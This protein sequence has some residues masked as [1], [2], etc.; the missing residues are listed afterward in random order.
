MNEND[1]ADFSD[2][3]TPC[4]SR[5]LTE[6]MPVSNTVANVEQTENDTGDVNTLIA[7]MRSACGNAESFRKFAGLSPRNL[8]DENA[9]IM[10]TIEEEE[11]RTD[12]AMSEIELEV[13]QLLLHSENEVRSFRFNGTCFF[14]YNFLHQLVGK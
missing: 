4:T 8:I 6:M 5:R 7:E 13:Q 10:T 12:D 2:S 9:D 14:N 3:D 1:P 11:E